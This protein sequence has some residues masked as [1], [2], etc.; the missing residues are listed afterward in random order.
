[1]KTIK[2]KIA[3]G[4]V[5]A[6]TL[7][8]ASTVLAAKGG[9]GGNGNGNGNGGGGGPPN[10]N[11]NWVVLTKANYNNETQKL[12]VYAEYLTSEDIGMTITVEGFVTDAPM[13]F[14]PYG[15]RYRY[16]AETADNL[17]GRLVTVTDSWDGDSRSAT[18]H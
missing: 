11:S 17:D 1:M 5:L 7:L 8:A 15:G 13:E 10:D 9:N 3:L 14:K 18:I 6:F 12:V 4:L 2:T 16:V